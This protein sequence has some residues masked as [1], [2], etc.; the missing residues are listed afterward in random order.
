M[1]MKN[2][3][4]DILRYRFLGVQMLWIIVFAALVVIVV[5]VNVI[6]YN[7]DPVLLASQT[8]NFTKL[9]KA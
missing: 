3:I 4:K 7:E 8:G 1:G 6:L 2:K 9:F 5:L